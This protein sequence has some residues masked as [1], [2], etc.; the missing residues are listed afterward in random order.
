[1]RG[2]YKNLLCIWEQKT[3]GTRYV[4]IP[5]KN[6]LLIHYSTERGVSFRK[7]NRYIEYRKRKELHNVRSCRSGHRTAARPGWLRHVRV[8]V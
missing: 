8:T 7:K 2:H 4:I 6:V 1:M 3:H 5:F